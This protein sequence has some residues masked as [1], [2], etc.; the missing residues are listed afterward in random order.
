MRGRDK[1]KVINLILSNHYAKVAVE[2]EYDPSF[3]IVGERIPFSHI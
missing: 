1:L 2:S 3:L